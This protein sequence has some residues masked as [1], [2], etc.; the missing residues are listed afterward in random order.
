MYYIFHFVEW[1]AADWEEQLLNISSGS[2]HHTIFIKSTKFCVKQMRSPLIA[3]F[4]LG[5]IHPSDVQRVLRSL[6]NKTSCGSDKISYRMIR[7]LVKVW[8]ALCREVP[9]EWRRAIIK[10]IF[11][12]GKKDRKDPSSYR[13]ISLTSCV[14]KFLKKDFILHSHD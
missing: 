13:P 2:N 1:T 9:E 7:R 10:P 3:T 4:D 14:A 5:N 11:K 8:L 12:G 6:P